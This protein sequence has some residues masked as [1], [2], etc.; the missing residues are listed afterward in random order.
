MSKELKELYKLLEKE[1]EFNWSEKCNVT[2]ERSKNLIVKNN[3]LELYDP[4]KPIIV[5]SDAS[6]YGAGA[7]MSNL[8]NGVENPDLFASSTLSSPTENNYS[9]LHRSLSNCLCN[10]KI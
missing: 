7:C 8:V 1:G 3:I 9:Q 6:P 4:E 5:A 10:K 2:F